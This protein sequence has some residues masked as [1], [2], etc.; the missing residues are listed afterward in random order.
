[1]INRSVVVRERVRGLCKGSEKKVRGCNRNR[2]LRF[3]GRLRV[4]VPYRSIFASIILLVNRIK[5]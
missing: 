5:A 4:G 1:M 3:R 2:G